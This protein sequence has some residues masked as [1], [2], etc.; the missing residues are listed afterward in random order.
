MVSL[1]EAKSDKGAWTDLYPH[2]HAAQTLEDHDAKMAQR[3]IGK[4]L[5]DDFKAI[6]SDRARS[7]SMAA[8]SS[9][10]ARSVT[11][12][13]EEQSEELPFAQGD[14]SGK[15]WGNVI[16]KALQILIND[17]SGIVTINALVQALMNQEGLPLDQEDLVTNAIPLC[18]DKTMPIKVVIKTDDGTNDN[19][20]G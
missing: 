19:N 7:I 18:D 5:P 15:K 2:L 4:V 17:R 9:Y 16:H 11:E 6:E 8:R 1:Y 3:Q 10:A 14:G 13:M 20:P 12:I